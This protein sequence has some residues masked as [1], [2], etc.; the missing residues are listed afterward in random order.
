MTVPR[1]DWWV[2]AAAG[3]A[4][5]QGA[6]LGVAHLR[7]GLAGV[8]LWFLGPPLVA[9][10]AAVLLAIAF[11]RT[12]K[13][14]PIR[15]EH[16][17]AFL[18]LW[19]AMASL[20]VVRT[21]P[22]SYDT[23]PSEVHFRLPLD[24]PVTVAWGGATR[25]HNYH[26]VM[27][28][29]KWAYDLLVTHEGRTHRGDGTQVDQYY[30][31]GLPVL[32]PA[33]GIVHS[34]RDGDPDEPPGY[35]RVRRVT[36]NHVI[37]RVA[38]DEYL[39][40]AHLQPGS[41][42]VSAG[43]RVRAGQVLGLVGNSGN[44]TEPHVHLHLQD[45]PRAYLGEAIPFEFR[46][47][48]LGDAHI[49]RGMPTGGQRNPRGV[50]RGE[51]LGQIVEHA[52][53]PGRDARASDLVIR[54]VTLIDGR[55][56]PPRP[57]AEI[58]IRDGIVT[59]AGATDVAAV[60]PGAAVLDAGGR[61]ALPGLIDLHQHAVV[62]AAAPEAWVAQGVTSVRDPGGDVELGRRLRDRIADGAVPGP[63]M[64]LGLTIDL[65]R[66]QTPDTVRT[67][68]ADEGARGI[69]LVKLY[70]RTP[71]EHARAAIAEAH[72]L[73]LPVTWH[74]GPPLGTAID[75]GVDGVEHLYVFRELMP[76]PDETAAETTAGAFRQ[77]YSRWARHLSPSSPET[78]TLFQRMAASGLVWTPTLTLADRIARGD[79]EYSQGWNDDDRAVG[80]AGF[81]RA[82]E[83][84]G[85]AHRHG[86]QIGAGTDTDDPGDLHR[87]LALLVR[88]GLTP[89]DALASATS[90][91]AAALRQEGWLGTIAAGAAAD[92]LIVDG[93]PLERIEDTARIWRVVRAG[94]V[95]D[96]QAGQ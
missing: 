94:Q 5:A 33:D 72:S 41:L 40:I 67:R 38:P 75:L 68:I 9:L 36:G 45:T 26:A 87:E 22:S 95:V 58:R 86:V 89:H 6:I 64:F 18:V 39:F 82:C 57:D 44:S 62:I 49:E 53:P 60:A 47:Y 74:L 80:E 21:Y 90:L 65:D 55:G 32:S 24:G 27:P 48:R 96:P 69:D 15:R 52:G 78:Q 4:V 3:L 81:E 84:V 2:R 66:D 93:H 71:V 17:A 92:L 56:G 59:Y 23:R 34:T 12:L 29:Q 13:R 83:M 19:L 61:T 91:A 11:V 35:W 10:T 54:G 25:A 70:L 85:E 31:Y 16:L 73:G 30:A 28:D 14:H 43:D 42:R 7:P 88:C 37:L 63:R 79:S 20:A 77:I 76:P 46:D 51:Y 1:L 8:V 50:R